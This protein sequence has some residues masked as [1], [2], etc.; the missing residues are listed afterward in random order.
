[1]IT[2]N[3]EYRNA[4]TA[5]HIGSSL[6]AE[7]TKNIMLVLD[8]IDQDEKLKK[9]PVELIARGI[10]TIPALHAAVIDERISKLMIYKA[11]NSFEDI[12]K[13]PER[14]DWYSYVVPGVLKHYDIPDLQ[15]HLGKRLIIKE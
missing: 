9:I 10:T 12:L 6:P 3:K 5:L 8:Y 11:I 7:R 14:K 4:I 13:H 1:M 2:F 15:K